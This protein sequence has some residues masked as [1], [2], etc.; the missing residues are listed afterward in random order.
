MVNN[1]EAKAWIKRKNNPGEI[2]RIVPDV[3]NKRA[4]TSCQLYIA[5]HSNALGRYERG[6]ALPSVEIAAKIANELETS[7]DYLIGLSE[8]E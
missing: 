7:L 1:T 4:V 3:E 6:E 2:V 8:I 5:L